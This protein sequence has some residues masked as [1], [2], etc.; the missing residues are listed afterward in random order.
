[1]I[2]FFYLLDFSKIGDAAPARAG[3]RRHFHARVTAVG[4][5]HDQPFI[6][7]K[8]EFPMHTQLA[9]VSETQGLGVSEAS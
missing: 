2:I 1:M 4:E 5:F 9:L 3:H 7:K 6:Q 8:E